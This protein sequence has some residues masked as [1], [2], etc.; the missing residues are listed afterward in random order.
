MYLTEGLLSEILH[1]PTKYNAGEPLGLPFWN[2]QSGR[3]VHLFFKYFSQ[4][5]IMCPAL[6]NTQWLWCLHHTKGNDEL[7][8]HLENT[9]IELKYLIS[10]GP[11]HHGSISSSDKRSIR[12]TSLESML[13]RFFQ[14]SG[15]TA[16]GDNWICLSKLDLRFLWGTP[17]K[18]Q[19]PV[20]TKSALYCN[21]FQS[22]NLRVLLCRCFLKSDGHYCM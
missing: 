5:M 18:S 3:N 4:K 17:K 9:V 20:L 2:L 16:S 10:S 8:D 6:C 13:P 22:P 1:F 15:L 14:L 7:R 12:E 11:Y 19:S 21:W